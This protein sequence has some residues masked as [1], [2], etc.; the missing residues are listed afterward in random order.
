[1]G[2]KIIEENGLI[3][4][5]H[6]TPHL[7]WTIGYLPKGPMPTL[8]MLDKLREIGKEEKCIFIQLEPNVQYSSHPE[9]ISGS[10]AIRQVS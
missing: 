6:K 2:V 3:F 5:I 10:P 8:E 7:P 1:M 9:F 4:S